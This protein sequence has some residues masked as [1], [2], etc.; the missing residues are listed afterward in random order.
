MI[1]FCISVGV[2][3]TPESEKKLDLADVEIEADDNALREF[4]ATSGSD[5]ALS[6]II[7]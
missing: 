5:A 6:G 1:Q 2:P 4:L 3:T 7:A